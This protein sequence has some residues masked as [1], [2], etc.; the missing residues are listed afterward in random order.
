MPIDTS[1]SVT[2]PSTRQSEQANVEANK[3]QENLAE[4]SGELEQISADMTINHMGT[5]LAATQVARS[6]AIIDKNSQIV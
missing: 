1:S 2:R 4:E 3:A 5:K 6:N